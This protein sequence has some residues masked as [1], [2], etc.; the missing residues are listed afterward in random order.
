MPPQRF[1][2][3]DV[4]AMT[5]LC[6]TVDK[7]PGITTNS[8]LLGEA[9]KIMSKVIDFSTVDKRYA[10]LPNRIEFIREQ[11]LFMKRP[12]LIDVMRNLSSSRVISTETL[13]NIE[14]KGGGSVTSVARIREALNVELVKR[15][16]APIDQ[17]A[18]LTP[19]PS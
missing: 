16:Y 4:R 15:G 18:L 12:D 8:H 9:H 2:H 1:N 14:K 3:T 6:A 17:A 13:R 5:E 11:I 10:G 19:M 7:F